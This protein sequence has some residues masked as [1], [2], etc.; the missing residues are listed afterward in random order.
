MEDKTLNFVTGFKTKAQVNKFLKDM[1]K[2]GC[3]FRWGDSCLDKESIKDLFQN[4]KLKDIAFTLSTEVSLGLPCHHTQDNL[5]ED[6]YTVS[7]YKY[8][9]LKL[10][11]MKDLIQE[12]DPVEDALKKLIK[13]NM[14]WLMDWLKDSL[15]EAIGRKEEQTQKREELRKD[16]EK[17][18]EK[19]KKE[20]K[21]SF[22]ENAMTFLIMVIVCQLF[23]ATYWAITT[24][25][26]W[27]ENNYLIDLGISFFVALIIF[28]THTHN[29]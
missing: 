3:S 20:S 19:M 13:E 6:G 14:S 16:L 7:E 25:A 24:I 22:W 2:L 18:K 15:E 12:W 4:Y 23:L 26:Y 11:D 27:F 8:P 5:L 9:A 1:D 28:F 17:L 10:A 21:T 29:D